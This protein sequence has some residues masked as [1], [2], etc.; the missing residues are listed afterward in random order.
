[1][2]ASSGELSQPATASRRA[3]DT[4]I[5]IGDF[6]TKGLD[7]MRGSVALARMNW[8]HSRWGSRIKQ[9]DLLYTLSLFV[10]EPVSFCQRYEWRALTNLEVQARFVFWREVG[11]RMG[12][13]D[14]PATSKEMWEWKENYANSTMEYRESN[15]QIGALTMEVLVAPLPH[16]LKSFSKEAGKVLVEPRVMKAFGWQNARPAVLYKIV[17]FVLRCRALF[18]ANFTMPRARRPKY[19]I[20]REVSATRPDG[21]VEIY[22]Q[23]EGFIFEPWYVPA[24]KSCIGKL[25][26]GVPGGTKW[27]SDGYTSESIGPERLRH[28]G[29]DL[30]V[31]EG[32]AIR[33]CPVFS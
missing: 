12:I 32:A 24:G 8:L 13:R 7:S 27:R 31:A 26:I 6:L 18:I 28:Q 25:G 14:I 4:A 20:S 9:D 21:K 16:F 2:L 11:T 22:V 23:R 19:L 30:V 33:G 15:S 10:F 17:P 5:V 1:V 29:R 3:E